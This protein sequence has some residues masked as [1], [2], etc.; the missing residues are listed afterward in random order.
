MIGWGQQRQRRPWSRYQALAVVAVALLGGCAV[1]PNYEAPKTEMP[2]LWQQKLT[3]G[4]A[5]GKAD[6]RTWWDVLNDPVLDG[7]ID[8]ATVGNLDLKQ[9]VARIQ[10]ARAQLGIAGG[11]QFPSVD[12]IG[13]IENSRISKGVARSTV[14]PQNRIDTF[15]SVG[16]DA[17]WELDFW[18]RIRRNVESADASLGG[19]IWDYRDTLVLLYADVATNY[20]E[21]RTLQARIQSALNN[22]KTQQGALRLTIDRNRAGLAPDLDVRQAQLNLATTE[23]V[24]P[25]LRNA[26]A[27]SVHRLAVLLGQ[28]PSAVDAKLAAPAPIPGPPKQVTVG[29][30]A[31]LLRQRPDIRFAERQLAAQTAQIGV[32]TADLYPRF[33]LSGTF[34]FEAFSSSNVFKWDSRS[35]S[36]GP[37]FNWNIFDAGR[38]RS[39]INLQDAMT[40][41]LLATYEQT[42]LTGVED[43]EDAIAA[44][45]EEK[46]RQ[47]ALRRSVVAA[48]ASN[49]LVETLYRTGLTDFQNVLDTQRS[50]FTQEDALAQSTGLVTENLIRLYKALG[51]GWAPA[52]EQAPATA[53]ATP[54]AKA[55]SEGARAS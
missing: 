32:A 10:E 29:L 8:R 47:E 41:R 36:F 31:E 34:A 9:A 37:A 4:L 2:D 26:L 6:L 5:E 30:P 51:G 38:I 1:G 54:P 3:E 16:L 45:T 21:I 24:V 15:Y 35:Y 20:V 23:A 42:V 39:N 46:I 40:Q 49:R 7:L 27:Q 55:P 11:Q 43:V 17:T 48:Q 19:S 13:T 14:P 53:G 44:Y 33:T 28:F 50:L 22:V 25:Q 12:A 52:T 18:G